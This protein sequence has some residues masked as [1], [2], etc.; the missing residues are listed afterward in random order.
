MA[1]G[2][3]LDLDDCWDCV[4]IGAGPA[5]AIA[6]RQTALTGLKTLLV[7]RRSFPRFKVCGA[8]LNHRALKALEELGL[9]STIDALGGV[10]ID[11][12]L[13]H[14]FGGAFE[15]ELPAGIAL[16]RAQLDSALMDAAVD[17]GASLL[18]TVSAK[19]GPCQPDSQFRVVQLQQADSG[20]SL[21]QLRSR[22]VRARVVIAADG[23]GHPSLKSSG[24]FCEQVTARSHVGIGACLETA[25]APETWVQPGRIYMAASRHGYGGLVRV[26]HGGLNLA[27]AVAPSFLRSQGSPQAAFASLLRSAG[28]PPLPSAELVWR[29]TPALSRMINR[30]ADHRVLVVGDSAGYV[31][32]FTGEGMAWALVGGRAVAESAAL[33]AAGQ[34]EQAAS[35]WQSD[36]SGLVRRRQSWCRRLAW[37]LRHPAAAAVGVRM[38][39]RFPRMTNRIVHQMNAEDCLTV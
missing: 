8:C 1:D 38:A 39:N 16:S 9:S 25:A 23:L 19:L 24:R 20:S 37:L 10:A 26:E 6:A 7:E 12:F 27:A 3:S 34:C 11:S 15:S 31:E 21:C 5:G 30:V 17:A 28:F 4:V 18:T 14:G 2:L 35:C 36:W 32:P 29:G 33:C 22:D 13:L